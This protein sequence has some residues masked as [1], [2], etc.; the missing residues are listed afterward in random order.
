MACGPGHCPGELRPTSPLALSGPSPTQTRRSSILKHNSGAAKESIRQRNVKTQF[1]QS[2]KW[3]N[4]QF[5]KCPLQL[6][7]PSTHKQ[8]FHMQ[9]LERLFRTY[10]RN[11]SV[12]HCRIA[13][14]QDKDVKRHNLS[15]KRMA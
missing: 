10:L 4:I 5:N 6:L 11:Y 14:N 3:K 9:F 15:M 7:P 1:Q 12:M 2:V 13:Y 8:I